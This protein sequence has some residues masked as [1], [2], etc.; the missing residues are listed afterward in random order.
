MEELGGNSETKFQA[1]HHVPSP[2]IT[3]SHLLS[4]HPWSSLVSLVVLVPVSSPI[5]PSSHS[6]GDW[7]LCVQRALPRW[8]PF[9]DPRAAPLTLSS[10]LL[11]RRLQE[12]RLLTSPQP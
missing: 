8:H 5:F 6:W 12:H 3:S 7:G 1:E 11:S 10:F 4:V 9:G 2:D